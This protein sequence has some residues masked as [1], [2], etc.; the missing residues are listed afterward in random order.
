MNI[1]EQIINY[2]KE[3]QIEMKKVVWPDRRYVT[4][5]TLVVL[6]LVF[7]T[8]AYIMFVDLI[9]AKIFGVLLR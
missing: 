9:L 5:A 1:K 4:T 8:G 7:L 3:T 2:L 6:A